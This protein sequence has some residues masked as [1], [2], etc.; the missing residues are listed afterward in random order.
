MSGYRKFLSSKRIKA[1][2]SGIDVPVDAINGKLFPWQRDIVHWSL[3]T[4]RSALFEDCG[5]GKTCQ[6]L[7]WADELI[8]RAGVNRVL[9]LCPLAVA[10]QTLAE[11]SRFAIQSPVNVC[12]E[13]S[14]VEAGITIANYERLHKFDTAVFD[15]VVPDE[16]SI[17]KS[18]TGKTKREL[19]SAF[20]HCR[21]KLACTATP[22]P[23]DLLELGNHAEFLEVMPSNEMIARWFIADSMHAGHYR[24]MK[25]AARDYWK[26]VTTWAVSL[27]SPSDLGHD[28]AGF[29]LPPLS[30]EEIVVD[31]NDN[32]PGDG[33]LFS[34]E[35]I[36][37]TTIHREKRQSAEVRAERVAELVNSD[38]QPWVVWCDLNVEADNLERLIPDAVEVRGSDSTAKKEESLM[39]FSRGEV[40]VIITKPD[41]AGF[42]LNWQ[43]CRRVAFIGLSYSFEKF[44][45]AVRRCW[46]FGQTEPVKVFVISTEAEH[47]ISRQVWQKQSTHNS[48]KSGIV[49]AVREAQL[50]SMYGR[51]ELKGYDPQ[52]QMEIPQWLLSKA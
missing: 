21:F 49:E 28:D 36:N 7:A 2:Q 13:A 31:S 16:S 39:A 23:N 24:L 35:P 34:N 8:R 17:L 43:H 29:K 42:G 19:I 40:R 5:L 27:S 52:M 14:E 33:W 3:K 50:A 15:A 48:L 45:Q 1:T 32:N 30:I 12:R 9:I 26:W 41:I 47:C 44:Y 11:A 6:Q 22:A 20:K 37:A 38:K 10:Q 25:H 46:R 51:R 18:Y 4:G